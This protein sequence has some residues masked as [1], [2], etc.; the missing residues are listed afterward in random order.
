MSLRDVRRSG[1]TEQFCNEIPRSSA[2]NACYGD[3]VGAIAASI[4]STSGQVFADALLVV[5]V[6]VNAYLGWS[7]GLIRRL[8]TAVGVFLAC[9]AASNLGNAIAALI[10][11]HNQQANA[12]AF[13]A[14]FLFVVIVVEVLGTLLNERLQKV[15][16]AAFDRIG[17]LLVGAVVGVA[18]VLILF[19]VAISVSGPA[20]TVHSTMSQDIHAATLSGQAVRLEP[21]VRTLFGPVLPSNLGDHFAQN[22]VVV[23]PPV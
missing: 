15:V 18:E 16:V 3:L 13:V 10:H 8:F 21:Q 5:A 14:V 17:G 23:T 4:D 19:L 11:S 2:A 9:F 7:H 6:A 22:A 12:W 1:C 20:S